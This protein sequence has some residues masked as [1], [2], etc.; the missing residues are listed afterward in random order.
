MALIKSGLL[1]T[2]KIRTSYAQ[3]VVF[4]AG[5]QLSTYQQIERVKPVTREEMKQALFSI[6]PMKSLGPDGYSSAFLKMLG[7]S[8][9]MILWML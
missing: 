6:P 9:E 1:G 2:H 3:K 5:P 7:L 8:W 4:E